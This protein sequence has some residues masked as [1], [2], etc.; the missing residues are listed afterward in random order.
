[1][2]RTIAARTSFSSIVVSTAAWIAAT[3]A[4]SAVEPP[5]SGVGVVAAAAVGLSS[6]AGAVHAVSSSAT[7]AAPPIAIVRIRRESRMN[8]PV[9]R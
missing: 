1:M 2:T 3:S 4:G 9:P 7:S 6:G 5:A 8:A